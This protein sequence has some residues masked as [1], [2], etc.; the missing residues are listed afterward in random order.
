MLKRNSIKKLILGLATAAT[1]GLTANVAMAELKDE[2]RDPY[3]ESF[4]GKK[5]AFVPVAMGVD[6]TEGWADGIRSAADKYGFEF[7]VRDPNWSTDAGTQAITALIAEK[8]DIIV[9][10]NPDVQSYAR[11]LKKAEKA[12]INVIQVN[13]KSSYST[14]VYVGA[15]WVEMGEA[16]ANEMVKRCGKD[17][18]KSGKVAIIQGVLTGAASVYQIGG[19][20]NVL[21]GRDDIEIVANQAA[22]W[23]ASKAKAITQTVLQQHPDLCAVFGFWDSM[24]LGV[25]AAVK[26]AGKLDQVAILTNGGG[27]QM[28]CDNVKSGIFDKV[29]SYDVPGQARD[30][31]DMIKVIFQSNSKPGDMRVALYTPLKVISMENFDPTDCWSMKK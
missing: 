30:M 12:G 25:G 10:H 2:L 17:S 22:D 14:N 18:G 11:L 15:D 21:E 19:V 27:N 1:F 4:K 13:M 6:L 5:V 31:V 16:G 20:M 29:W 23:D 26:E 8:P 3:L 24:T 9:V 7:V 28:A